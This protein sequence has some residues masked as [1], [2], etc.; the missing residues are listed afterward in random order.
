MLAPPNLHRQNIPFRDIINNTPLANELNGMHRMPAHVCHVSNG[1]I[2]A[3]LGPNETSPPTVV[4]IDSVCSSCNWRFA[5]A[6]TIVALVIVVDAKA[7]LLDNV[8]RCGLE[9]RMGIDLDA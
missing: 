4:V 5:V 7:V 6:G 1:I 2:V 3:P 9:G 8:D